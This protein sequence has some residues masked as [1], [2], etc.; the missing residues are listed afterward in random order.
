MCVCV[1]ISDVFVGSSQERT[2]D[3][4]SPD[5]PLSPIVVQFSKYIV[6]DGDSAARGGGSTTPDSNPSEE[7]I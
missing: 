5:L 2:M 6:F 7:H 3:R 1:Q 4:V